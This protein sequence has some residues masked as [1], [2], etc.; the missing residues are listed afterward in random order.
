MLPDGRVLVGGHSPIAT[1]SSFETPVLQ[2]TLGFCQPQREPSFEIFEPPNLFYG[3]RPVIAG[4]SRAATRGKTLTIETPDAQDVSSVTIVRNTAITHLVDADQR[5]VELPVV[6]RSGGTVTV[7]VTDNAAVLPDGPYNVFV[8]K[9]YAK[10]ETPSVGRQVFVGHM[11]AAARSASTP[12]D[13]PAGLP[14]VDATTQ[15]AALPEPLPS[16]PVVVATALLGGTFLLR[17]RV[18]AHRA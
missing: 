3:Q 8:N 9:T 2:D 6:K 4:V 14:V 12:V 10:G 11:T 5:V 16:L 1:G 15:V 7:A 18:L 13:A 17:R